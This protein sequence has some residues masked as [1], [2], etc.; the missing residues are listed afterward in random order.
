MSHALKPSDQGARTNFAVDMLERFGSTPDFLR[1]VCFFHEASFHVNG[2]LKRFNCRIWSSHNQHVIC[3]LERGSPQV[4]VWPGLMHDR[5]IEWFFCSENTVTGHSYLNMLELYALTQLPPKIILQQNGAPS[6]FCHHVRNYLDREMAGR[7]IGRSGPITWPPRSSDLT[8]LD[9][10]LWGYVR[11]LSIR[12]RSSTF[13]TWK[14][15]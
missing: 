7:W 14:P 6:H 8:A 5:M 4:N 9:Y 2:V 3:E 12:L 10:F 13:N 11:T 15:P 1:Q